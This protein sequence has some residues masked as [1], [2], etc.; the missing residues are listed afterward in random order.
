MPGKRNFS[1]LQLIVRDLKASA[2]EQMQVNYVLP[3][4]CLCFNVSIKNLEEF[5]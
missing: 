2:S 5:Q 4:H 3:Q 1:E